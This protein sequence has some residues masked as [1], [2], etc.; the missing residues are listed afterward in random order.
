MEDKKIQIVE[1]PRDAMQGIKKFIPTEDKINY[2]NSLIKVGFDIID[3]GSFV[4]PKAVPQMADTY[5]VISQ[6]KINDST[7][8]LAIVL[9]KRGILDAS[10]FEKI[11]ILGYPLS[12]SEIFQKNNS[13]MDIKS[14][15][16][17]IDEIL[18]LCEQKNKSLLVYLSMAFGNPYGEEWNIN[19]LLEK[20]RKLYQKG[21]RSISLADT[22]GQ[23]SSQLISELYSEVNNNF[24]DLDV[25]LHLHCHPDD[26]IKKIESAWNVGCKRYDVAIGG[27]GGCPF[28]NSSLIGNLGTEKILNFIAKN[29]IPHSLDMLAFENAYNYSKKIFN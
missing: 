8:L 13:N 29:K 26:A 11:N 15:M 28:T 2:I 1:C 3:F 22:T 20:I 19:I 27:Y 14:S 5:N 12:I 6:L 17:F 16:I 23:A 4:S 18:N 7:S 9:N 24:T 25:G 10:S 21:V